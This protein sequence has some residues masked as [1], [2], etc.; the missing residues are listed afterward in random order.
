MFSRRPAGRRWPFGSPTNDAPKFRI[1]EGQGERHRLGDNDFN[2][3]I[4]YPTSANVKLLPATYVDGIDTRKAPAETSTS[5]NGFWTV[6]SL[7]LITTYNRSDILRADGKPDRSPTAS[8]TTLDG[9]LLGGGSSEE[10]IL[11][12][13]TGLPWLTGA[14]NSTHA[15][16]SATQTIWP[17]E[18]YR[19]DSTQAAMAEKLVQMIVNQSGTLSQQEFTSDLQKIGKLTLLRWGLPLAFVDSAPHQQ[20]VISTGLD[21]L[22]STLPRSTSGETW[23]GPLVDVLE[24]YSML[25]SVDRVCLACLFHY[26][27]SDKSE[28]LQ[29]QRLSRVNATEKVRQMRSA[30]R[31]DVEEWWNQTRR[32]RLQLALARE[33]GIMPAES[34]YVAFMQSCQRAGQVREVE[35][36]FHHYLDFH[37]NARQ[38]QSLQQHQHQQSNAEQP[39][40][41]IY[42]EYIKTLVRMGR[43]DQAQDVFN[44]MKRRGVYPSVITFGAMLDGYGRQMDLRK[45]RQVLVSLRSA[46]HLPTLEMYTSMMANYIKAGE[47]KRADEVYRQLLDR[48]DIIMD[49]QSKNVVDNLKRLG[50]G[51]HVQDDNLPLENEHPD[52]VLTELRRMPNLERLNSVIHYN[53]KL[54]RYADGM[55]MPQFVQSYRQLIGEGL[56]PNSITFNILLGALSKAG[57]IEDGLKVLELMKTTEE[58]QPDVVSF[59]TLIASAVEQEKVELGWTL[60]DEM[61]MRSIKPSVYTYVSLIEMVALDPSNKRG[62][63]IMKK[64]A[65]RGNHQVR[66]PVKTQIEDLVGLGFAGELYNQLLNQGLEPNQHVFGGLLN[67]TVHGGFADLAQHVYQEMIYK[68]IEPNTA[69][70]T[71]LIKGFAIRR[72]FESGWKVWRHMIDTDIPRNVIT[73]HHLIR[74]CER[75][76]PDPIGM[77]KM[78]DLPFPDIKDMAPKTSEA[79]RGSLNDTGETSEKEAEKPVKKTGR[80][81]LMKKLTP[82]EKRQHQEE[83]HQTKKQRRLEGKRVREIAEYANKMPQMI[84]IEIRS[85]MALDHVHWPRVQQFRKSIV[86]RGIWDPIEREAGPVM[87]ITAAAEAAAETNVH[88]KGSGTGSESQNNRSR[89]NISSTG[90]DLTSTTYSNGSSTDARAVILK[91]IYAGGGHL[92][93]PKRGARWNMLLKWDVESKVPMLMRDAKV[94]SASKGNG[95]SDSGRHEGEVGG[96]GHHDSSSDSSPFE[97]DERSGR[98]TSSV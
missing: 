95:G 83:R 85:Q 63:A 61:R 91:E 72:D 3:F 52:P 56:R 49:K 25:Q 32:F 96:S 33:T 88:G 2:P 28:V 81:K 67:L 98:A 17:F 93:K 89:A 66:F 24:K 11:D 5:F 84:W 20:D 58:G 94:A 14:A 6:D 68:K 87:S 57:Q 34:E 10:S 1:L 80:P 74:L 4:N 13:V 21:T 65:V 86:D 50:G 70:M 54:K 55:N 22:I 77:A 35:L 53:H 48:S 92:Y 36:T 45:M 47:L 41:Q 30:R 62:R 60:Y 37:Q 23:A 29:E 15:S 71:T 82:E 46:G 40:E 43:M 51:Q 7:P 18:T 90:T 59:S 12:K 75:S 42:R 19:L 8:S 9:V 27:S 16:Q 64:H 78:L 44:S 73:Y 97:G 31:I 76:L 79:K 39:S 69:I 38:P 26:V